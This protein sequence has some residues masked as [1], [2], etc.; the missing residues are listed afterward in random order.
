MKIQIESTSNLTTMD[1]VPVRHWKGRTESGIECD[2][3]VHRIAGHK[4]QDSA[5][6]ESELK[7]MDPPG[8]P[9]AISLRDIL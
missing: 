8:G 1:G 5:Q 7:E 2:V 6:F 4:G 3:F 9:R